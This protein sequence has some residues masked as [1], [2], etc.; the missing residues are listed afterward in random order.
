[1]KPY[2]LPALTAGVILASSGLVS[3]SALGTTARTDLMPSCSGQGIVATAK[4]RTTPRLAEPTASA[5]PVYL[6]AGEDFIMEV[7]QQDPTVVVEV[8]EAVVE[9][10]QD[11]F[12]EVAQG[13]V[14]VVNAAVDETQDLYYAAEYFVETLVS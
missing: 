11:V 9:N 14:N 1:M 5:T 8:T 12:A 7:I 13:A 2:T 10:A 4:I 6:Q 3:S